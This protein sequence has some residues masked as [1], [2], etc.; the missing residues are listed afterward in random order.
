MNLAR[1]FSQRS[2]NFCLPLLDLNSY[3]L[4]C[5]QVPQLIELSIKFATTGPQGSN[6][7]T[8]WKCTFGRMSLE[9]RSANVLTQLT[10]WGSNGNEW[11][12]N[13]YL[14]HAGRPPCEIDWLKKFA[15]YENTFG[16][17]EGFPQAGKRPYPL[18]PLL[19][20][21]LSNP[22]RCSYQPDPLLHPLE[23]LLQ[24]LLLVKHGTMP[25][26]TWP[27]PCPPCSW[28][29]SS[30]P[31]SQRRFLSCQD[32]QHSCLGLAP[33]PCGAWHMLAS[34]LV[35]IFGLVTTWWPIGDNLVTTWWPLG[36]H[37][38]TTW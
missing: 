8:S 20:L 18:H 7:K 35:L 26:S 25:V 6:H 28:Q 36:D 19:L 30:S 23:L 33:A 10:I 31:S 29:S 16:K 34:N 21:P 37:M 24:V 27:P 2:N 32:L 15:G 13:L 12:E 22:R 38:V 17:S 9:S 5:T 4:P 1:N 14:L 3:T 11:L